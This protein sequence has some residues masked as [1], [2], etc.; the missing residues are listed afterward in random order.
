M[1]LYNLIK[2]LKERGFNLVRHYGSLEIWTNGKK[3]LTV[4]ANSDSVN[5]SVAKDLLRQSMEA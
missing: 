1:S 3:Y 2:T 4:P 5:I